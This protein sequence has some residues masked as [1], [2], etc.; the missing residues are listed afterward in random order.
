[1]TDACPNC[2]D[3]LITKSLDGSVKLRIAGAV[4]FRGGV[5][6][7]QCYWCKAEVELPLEL[8]KSVQPIQG[9]RLVIVE[10]GVVRRAKG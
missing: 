2:R 6:F 4:T 10:R 7:G 1:M 8:S 5:A 9:E 3:R